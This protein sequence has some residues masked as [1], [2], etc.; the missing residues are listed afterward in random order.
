MVVGTK[1]KG[2]A[3]VVGQWTQ[4]VTGDV[5]EVDATPDGYGNTVRATVEN[6]AGRREVARIG[7]LHDGIWVGYI[8]ANWQVEVQLYT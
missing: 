6:N 3:S 4:Q 2:I 8:E 1:V 5:I 7:E